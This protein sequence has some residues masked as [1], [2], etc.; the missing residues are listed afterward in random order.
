MHLWK[1]RTGYLHTFGHAL[2]KHFVFFATARAISQINYR[3]VKKERVT[4][5]AFQLSLQGYFCSVS[6]KDL[7]AGSMHHGGTCLSSGA[8]GV[9][10]QI[11]HSP[12]LPSSSHDT[13]Y[14]HEWCPDPSLH[15]ITVFAATLNTVCVL[16][17]SPCTPPGK[18]VSHH[19]HT[20]PEIQEHLKRLLQR[21]NSLSTTKY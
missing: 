14:W 13:K 9:P 18:R 10:A 7:C 4:P 17:G 16:R 5:G 3:A 21:K 12:H 6:L 11:R 2:M 20:W 19:R 8:A 1:F 15:N